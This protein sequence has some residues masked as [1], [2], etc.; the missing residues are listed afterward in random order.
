M[1]SLV[2]PKYFHTNYTEANK[3][4]NKTNKTYMRGNC[5][6]PWLLLPSFLEIYDSSFNKSAPSVDLALLGHILRPLSLYFFKWPRVDKYLE[7]FYLY[8]WRWIHWHEFWDRS[9]GNFL[10]SLSPWMA[11][12]NA[13]YETKHSPMRCVTILHISVASP[14]ASL[15]SVLN[16]NAFRLQH[17]ICRNSLQWKWAT[18]HLV[19]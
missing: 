11:R 6:S 14:K 12:R 2:V 18:C 4:P 5:S 19:H 16:I 7:I 13:L 15:H 10:I 17:R 3:F 9:M 1:R 8:E